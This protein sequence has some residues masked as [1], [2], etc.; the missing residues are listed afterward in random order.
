MTVESL[1]PTNAVWHRFL[2]R[3]VRSRLDGRHGLQA[4]VGNS[5][6]LFADKILRMGVGLL[7]GV[8]VVRFLGPSQLGLLAYAGAFGGLFGSLA[9]LGLDSIVVRELVKHP[10]RHDELMGSAF[11][12][13]LLGG[14]V[15]L[16][17]SLIAIA[18]V[19][20]GETFT[21]V[22]VACTSVGFIFQ[23]LNT[24]DFFFQATVQS[25][26][27][28]YSA[29]AAFI[30]MTI[31]KIVLLLTSGS[32]LAFALAGLGEVL[33]T[34]LFLLVA[35]R[36]KGR[37]M[38]SWRYSGKLARELMRQSWPLVLS[39]LTI[40]IYMRIDQIM[41]GQILD[42][43]E[44]GL[45]AAS[46]RLSE[47]WYF[48]PAGIASSVFP[49]LMSAKKQ[50]EA[51]YRLRVQQFYDLMTWI[52]IVV[53]IATTFASH[54][55]VPLLYGRAF[56]ESADVLSIQIW[57]GVAVCMGY[58][59]IYWMLTENLQKYSV[60]YTATGAVLNVLFNLYM[61]PAYGIRGA[62]V[63]TLIAQFVPNIL[64]IFI[65]QARSNLMMM[66]RSFNAPVRLARHYYLER[67]R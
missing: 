14:V 57:A 56:I 26:Y 40:M 8:W 53:A 51:A 28:V 18:V 15:A 1:E 25:K 61:I 33:L 39:G 5:G 58:V 35:Y 44:V 3:F 23:S 64:Q 27:T 45:F 30:L 65:P 47:I 10:E 50:G 12:L 31:T 20:P 22:L 43:R 52:G 41:I 36:L 16:A 62:A 49:A 17:L 46:V 67:A 11:R 38:R 7:V 24:P 42:N 29:N 13:K 59:H 34:S 55:I 2:P 19:K 54:W 21:M 66:I 6:W 32:L 37:S 4:I 9:T 60:Y 48:V 63:A